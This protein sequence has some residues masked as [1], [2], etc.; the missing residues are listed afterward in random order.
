MPVFV[1]NG[2][3]I[4]MYIENNNPSPKTDS[5]P[6]GLDK[7]TRVVEVYPYGTSSTEVF[8]DD[9]ITFDGANISTRYTSK[10][11][12]DVAT[13][14]LDKAQGTYAGVITDRNVEAIF[15]VSKNHPK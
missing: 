15:N 10:V 8:E 7:T 2:A 6:K 14:T 9:G 13:L 1:K 11:E 4:P 5:N 12:N 3:I